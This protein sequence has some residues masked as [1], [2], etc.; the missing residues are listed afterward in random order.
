[1]NRPVRIGMLSFAHGHVGV[2]ARELAARD[3][4][5]LT[6]CW[7]SDTDRMHAMAATFGMQAE[8]DLDRFLSRDD[9]ECVII[10]S[11]TAYH[12]RHA[13]M[14]LRRGKAV[15]LQKP[16]A[17]T[18]PECDEII[19]EAA[20]A[21]RWFSLAFQMRCDPVNIAIRSIVQSHRLGRL[22]FI[23]R[24]HCIGVLFNDQFVNGATRWHT[25][26]WANRGMF[27]D[28]AIHAIDWLTWT[29]DRLPESCTAEISNTIGRIETDDTGVAIYRYSDGLTATVMNSSVILAGENTTEI[30]GDKGV[31]IQNHGDGP[32]SSC[33]PA[34]G[35][36]ALKLWETTDSGS[37]W[38]DLGLPIQQQGERIAAVVP[39]FLSAYR[40]G[41]PMCSAQ[42]GRRSVEMCLAA[43]RS[44]HLGQRVRLPLT[45]DELDRV[46]A[47]PGQG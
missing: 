19:R 8:P 24:R 44:S 32:S 18:L 25:E 46:P 36:C 37:G 47:P 33:M 3:D 5:E 21:G 30:Y 7:D 28:D 29:L 10:G 22:I 39:V 42:E 38:T 41:V 26:Q 1:M 43:Y 35:G 15:L 12:A 27:F 17:L 2:Y 11:E 13:V 4:A 34:C 20:A 31:L 9:V 16:M 14:A 6:A 23:R 45:H 40:A